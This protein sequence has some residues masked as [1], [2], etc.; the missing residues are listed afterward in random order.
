MNNFEFYAPTRI[1]FG[2]DSECQVGSL[3]K[4]HGATKVLLHFGGQ[5]AEKS[6]LLGRVRQSLKDSN[7]DFVELGGVVPNP[8]LSLAHKGIEL[9]KAEGVDFILS[10]GGGS[11]ID[12]SKAIGWGLCY[13]GDVW[14][15]YTGVGTCHTCVPQ[16]CILTLA[17]AGSEMSNGSVITKEEGMLKRSYSDDSCRL[18]FSILNPEL[19]YTLPEYQTSCGIVDII[20]HTMERYFTTDEP[21]MMTDA[22]SEGIIR[23]VMAN[24]AILMKDP[25][26][27]NARGEIMWSGSLS[28]NDL[29][30]LGVGSDW[31]THEMEHELSGLFDVAHGAGLAAIWGSWARF[32]YD[33]KP[34]RFETFAKNVF[35]LTGDNLVIRGIEAMEAFFHSVNMP[36][37]IPELLGRPVTE[38]ELDEL[39]RKC[40]YGGRS[41][42]GFKSLPESS[43]R[44]IYAMANK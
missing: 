10:V 28:H 25:T 7:V 44:A 35:G 1:V 8:R 6:G 23:N 20:M 21:M 22:I 16:A 36:I 17:A 37:S 3:L 24:G 30:G 18:K 13:D 29:T 4:E 40:A 11:V 27:Y 43:M 9:C 34:E 33:A 19:T 2:K 42:G 26:N 15:I 31:S 39:A 41:I 38:A 5:S 32:V 14:D 12:S